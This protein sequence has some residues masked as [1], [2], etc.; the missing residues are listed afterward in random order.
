MNGRFVANEN[1]LGGKNAIRRQLLE[2]HNAIVHAKPAIDSRTKP[3]AHVDAKVDPKKK[4]NKVKEP[5]TTTEVYHSFRKVAEIKSGY[6]D[7]SKPATYDLKKNALP[8]KKKKNDFINQEHERNLKSQYKRVSNVGKS[9]AERKKNEFD[10]IAHPVTFFRR[11][12]ESKKDITLDFMFHRTT[13]PKG[14][15]TGFNISKMKNKVSKRPLSS[16]NKG[17]DDD[18]DDLQLE[19]ISVNNVHNVK[20]KEIPEFSGGFKDDDAYQDYK[21]KVIDHIIDNRLYKAIDLDILKEKI[22]I[23]YPAM[24]RDKLDNMFDQINMDLDR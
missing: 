10:P 4:L 16:Y 13:G 17:A 19:K 21:L 5:F 11:P 18:D 22:K 1:N 12:D 6:I 20:E 14:T 3:P 15:T 24:E 2:H 23:K 8:M 9:M 7:A